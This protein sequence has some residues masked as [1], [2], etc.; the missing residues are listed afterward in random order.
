MY[1]LITTACVIYEGVNWTVIIM[2]VIE[3]CFFPSF[4][5]D[6][7]TKLG[8]RIVKGSGFW[9]VLIRLLYF[10]HWKLKDEEWNCFS[11]NCTQVISHCFYSL[12]L[13]PQKCQFVR[14]K[15]G[16]E[17]R[18]RIPKVAATCRPTHVPLGCW[19]MPVDLTVDISQ[20]WIECYIQIIF[21][22]CWKKLPVE[23]LVLP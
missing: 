8:V 3:G 1:V 16:W 23:W 12:F 13:A 6:H 9:G 20:H 19:K 18:I 2:Y 17:N 7:G 11:W 15:P 4:P 14:Q 10:R 21:I 22:L 5:M